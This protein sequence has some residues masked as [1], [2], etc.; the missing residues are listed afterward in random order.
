M[1]KKYAVF[2][3]SRTDLLYATLGHLKDLLDYGVLTGKINY[4]DA[5]NFRINEDLFD[6][7]IESELINMG[8]PK[9]YFVIKA[10]VKDEEKLKKDGFC[11]NKKIKYSIYEL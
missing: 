7:K 8:L 5:F 10:E 1:S 3:S 11:K 4:G 9:Y 6:A 2:A